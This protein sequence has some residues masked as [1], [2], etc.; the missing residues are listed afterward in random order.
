MNRTLKIA[1]IVY[2]DI[3]RIE[4]YIALDKPAVAKKER[5]KIIAAIIAI[6]DFPNA[7]TSLREKFGVKTDLF[8]RI[9]RPY[10]I[11]HDVSDEVIN[12]YRVLDCRT[13]YLRTLDLEVPLAK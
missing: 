1:P 6:E 12:V 10:I 2:R 11:I 13:D 9:V 3:K 5:E 8:G 7:S 4:E